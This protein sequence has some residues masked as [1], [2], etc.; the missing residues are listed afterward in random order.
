MQLVENSA[1]V[2]DQYNPEGSTSYFQN[3]REEDR[4]DGEKSFH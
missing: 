4:G 1:K 3:G 2:E